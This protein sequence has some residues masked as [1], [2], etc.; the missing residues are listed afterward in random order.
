MRYIESSS[1]VA[2]GFGTLFSQVAGFHR[3]V[4][5]TTLDKACMQFGYILPIF[6]HLS[7][8]SAKIFTI[9]LWTFLAIDGIIVPLRKG[10]DFLKGIRNRFERFCYAHRNWGIPNLML[11]L[12]LASG[13]VSIMQLMGYDQIYN[14]LCFDRALILQGQVWRLVTYLFTMRSGNLLTTLIMLY[15]YYSLGRAVEATWGT[16]KFNLYYLIGVILMDVFAMVFGGIEVETADGIYSFTYY[17]TG[18]MT[19]FLH[20]S[21]LICFATIYTESQFLLFFIIPIKAWILALFYLVIILV[22]VVQMC[23]PYLFFPHCLFPLVA[24]L[25]YFLFFGK[26]VL[27]V[28]PPFMRPKRVV[29]RGGYTTV[30]KTPRTEKKEAPKPYSHRCVICGRTDA[31]NPQL[32]FRYC[33][34][35]NGYFCYCEDHINNHTHVE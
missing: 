33:S 16:F 14:V 23:T 22:Q 17:Y 24:L 4:P 27:N 20:L 9:L 6:V 10:C 28:L 13:V 30:G 11:Y 26:D 7:I 19:T 1:L 35:C 29:Y 31:S 12:V 25:N 2:A 34:R 18:S 8:V 32:E 5:S 15:C 21:L 3:A